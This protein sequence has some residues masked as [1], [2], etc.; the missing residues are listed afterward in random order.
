MTL[1]ESD[2]DRIDSVGHVRNQYVVRTED[3][4][5]QLRN[6]NGYCCFYDPE[7]KTCR[8]YEQRPEGCRFY[9]IIYDV[10]RHRCVVDRDCPSRETVT[11]EEINRV[12]SEVRKLVERL[13]AEAK[14]R[15]DSR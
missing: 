9:P 15:E 1:T 12:C 8:V 2:M 4:F 6:R 7:T 13:M 11:K 10:R 5:F 14:N 3:G